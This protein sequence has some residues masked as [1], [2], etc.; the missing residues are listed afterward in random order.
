MQR[1]VLYSYAVRHDLP[2]ELLVVQYCEAAC[3]AVL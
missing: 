2:V 1:A 3:C